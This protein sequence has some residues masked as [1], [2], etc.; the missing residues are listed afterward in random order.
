[1]SE[2]IAQNICKNNSQI[3]DLLKAINAKNPIIVCHSDNVNTHIFE[4]DS[5][6]VLYSPTITN[7]NF[8][9]EIL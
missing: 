7:P 3:Q 6:I 2:T 1:M 8:M 5:K 4:D 9:V